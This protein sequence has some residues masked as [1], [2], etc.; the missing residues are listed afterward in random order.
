MEDEEAQEDEKIAPTMA[1][2]DIRACVVALKYSIFEDMSH[3]LAEIPLS[4]F[5]LEENIKFRA[6]YGRIL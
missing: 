5:H 4:C 2:S 3:S 6:K 1:E